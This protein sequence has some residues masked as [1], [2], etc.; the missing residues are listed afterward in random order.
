MKK[1]FCCLLIYIFI[2]L[3][4]PVFAD[5]AIENQNWQNE[6]KIIS[7]LDLHYRKSAY[8]V[9]KDDKISLF[10]EDGT[11]IITNVEEISKNTISVDDK[12]L[13]I[14]KRNGKYGIISVKRNVYIVEN[15]VPFLYDGFGK[16][17]N[18]YKKSHTQRYIIAEKDGK[19]GIVKLNNGGRSVTDFIYTSIEPL[20][21]GFVKVGINNEYGVFYAK[22]EKASEVLF[23]D[24]KVNDSYLM[25]KINDK[26][27][28]ASPSK[29]IAKKIVELLANTGRIALAIAFLPLAI[30]A[31]GL[32]I[33]VI[34]ES[35]K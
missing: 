30:P 27:H 13:L 32:L 14:I 24:V 25:V 33:Y 4:I 34:Y 35:H 8:I 31:A 26:W 5:S 23:E 16:S 6:Y 17:F 3:N 11:P 20:S 7:K 21:H 29:R 9:S 19:F 28:Y 12:V 1:L 15:V 2:S 10:L 18:Y 22:N